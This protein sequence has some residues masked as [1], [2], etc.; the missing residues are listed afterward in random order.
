M[1]NCYL[2]W[3]R[4]VSFWCGLCVQKGGRDVFG[5]ENFDFFNTLDFYIIIIGLSE[6][7][8]I[9]SIHLFIKLQVL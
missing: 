6:S 4:V 3:E 9:T 7:L 1:K 5:L 2:S 8:K